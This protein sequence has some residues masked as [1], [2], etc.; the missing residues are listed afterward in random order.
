MSGRGVYG[1][2]QCDE[3][4]DADRKKLCDGIGRVWNVS[5][6]IGESK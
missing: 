6:G 3:I 1:S 2:G 5:K 4:E